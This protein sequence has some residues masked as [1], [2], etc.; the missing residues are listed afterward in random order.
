MANYDNVKHLNAIVSECLIKD[1]TQT[2]KLSNTEVVIKDNI[3]TKGVKTTASSLILE[4]YVPVY[5]ATVV[6]KILAAGGE[7]V[8]KSSMDELGMGGYGTTAATGSVLNPLDNERVAGGSSS[9]SAAL[10]AAGFT[11]VSLGT[12]TGDS[13]RIPASYT[14]IVGFKPTYGRVSRYGVIPY[15]ASLDHVGIFANNVLN[16]ATM[17]EVIA[18]YD[19][20][21]QTSSHKEVE[22]YATLNSDIS[23][24]KVGVIKNVIDDIKNV[25]IKA[26]FDE[27]ISKLKNEGV[28]VVE[29]EFNQQY[30]RALN[31][32]YKILSNA[33][34]YSGHSNLN[35]VPYGVR[36]NGDSL[37]EIM[38][39]TRTKGFGY[40][41][42]SRF[43]LGAYSLSS[44]N[45]ERA[46]NQAKKVRRLIVDE[47][48][49][50]LELVDF[51]I[52]PASGRI[53]PKL[54]D[55]FNSDEIIAN[56]YMV[57]DNFTGNPGIVLPMCKVEN[58][59]V[60]VYLSTKAFNEKQLLTLSA[61]IEEV[62]GEL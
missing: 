36:E 41:V 10:V 47:I 26:S 27:L 58:M 44:D 7:I 20:L 40:Q 38:L 9:G 1:K 57:M 55:D 13:M 12:D 4:N 6:D 35:G 23:N 32:V 43:V 8:A 51:L 3:S 21:D 56:N 25:E 16:T 54:T 50:Q 62:V 37:D 53:A 31:I 42:R 5:N 49:Q 59:P 17:L 15:A 39:N 19:P 24:I 52:A 48:N 60:G 46:F 45:Y 14:G 61:L 29:V 30:F 34:A 18:G 11:N 28:E 2:G 33:E 22:D